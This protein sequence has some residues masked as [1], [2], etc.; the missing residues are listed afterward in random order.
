MNTSKEIR[1]KL[2]AISPNLEPIDQIPLLRVQKYKHMM[3]INNRERRTI[4]VHVT[5]DKLLTMVATATP[6]ERAVA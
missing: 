3:R 5:A 6:R 2:W 4:D 1:K